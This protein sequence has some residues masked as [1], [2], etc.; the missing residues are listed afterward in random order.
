MQTQGRYIWT[1]QLWQPCSY[2]P[3]FSLKDFASQNLQELTY[4][5]KQI[6]GN[7]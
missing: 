3:S 4:A 7:E 5:S 1:M 6:S 2:E